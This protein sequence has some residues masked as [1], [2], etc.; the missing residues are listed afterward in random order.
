M[1]LRASSPRRCRFCSAISSSASRCCP[2]A[3]H[4]LYVAP[5]RVLHFLPFAL[6]GGRAAL[7]DRW[8]VVSVPS[9][10]LALRGRGP[11]RRVD[12][13]IA[14]IGLGFSN[15]TREGLY[16]MPGAVAEA[17]RVA[18]IFGEE[19]IV[20]AAATKA[21]VFEAMSAA[22]LVHISTHGA[23]DVGAPAF[24][25]IYLT[26][27]GASDGRLFANEI[28]A[29][30][31]HHVELLTLSDRDGRSAVSMPMTIPAASRP[32]SSWPACGQSSVRFRL[33]ECRARSS[34]SPRCTPRSMAVRR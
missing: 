10:R 15:D 19:A 21:I 32:A 34:S 33:P 13:A 23:H 11:A 26:P 2:R 18:A 22:R 24:Q 6:L 8:T 5:H 7:A 20:D 29:L 1:R 12:R 27:D 17:R 16:A 14:S 30:D 9:V 31:L 3:L 25:T 28:L 4:V